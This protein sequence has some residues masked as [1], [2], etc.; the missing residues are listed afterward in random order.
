MRL[1]GSRWGGGGVEGG[2]EVVKNVAYRQRART[3]HTTKQNGIRHAKAHSLGEGSEGLTPGGKGWKR[4][5]VELGRGGG[6]CRWVMEA[7]G[8]REQ[9]G[10]GEREKM[11]ACVDAP[12]CLA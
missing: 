9:E 12:S 8:R 11:F 4:V 3:T 1:L 7:K 10:G 6:K 5:L 2:G